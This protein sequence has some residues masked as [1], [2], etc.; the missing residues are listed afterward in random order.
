MPAALFLEREGGVEI[1]GIY[2]EAAGFAHCQRRHSLRFT[3]KHGLTHTCRAAAEMRVRDYMPAA[4]RISSPGSQYCHAVPRPRN[5]VA[6]V[7]SWIKTA[8]ASAPKNEPRPP[9][10]LAP[11]STTAQMPCNG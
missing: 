11:P 5:P 3:F 4:I 1:R 10:M 9:K 2:L 8:P 6:A 7:I